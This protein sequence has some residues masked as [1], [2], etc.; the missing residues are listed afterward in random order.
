MKKRPSALAVA[1]L[2]LLAVF[3]LRLRQ[4]PA[5][6]N[7]GEP[8]LAANERQAAAGQAAVP[9]AALAQRLSPESW[10]PPAVFSR[11]GAPAPQFDFPR[12]ENFSRRYH[13]PVSRALPRGLGTR[14][15]GVLALTPE[16]GRTHLLPGEIDLHTRLARRMVFD[17]AALDA[18]LSGETVRALAPT[19]GDEVL[20]LEFHSVKTR[21]A[22]SHTLLGRVVGEEESSDALLVYH[23]GVIHGSV[24]RYSA[25]ADQH[26]EYR[27]LADGHMMVRELDPATM[28]A[29]CGNGPATEAEAL[30]DGASGEGLE[31]IPQ[32]EG[33]ISGDTAGWRTIDIVVGYD[34]GARVEDGGYTQIEARIISSVDRMSAAFANSAI[35]NT[36]LM[37]LGTVE[38]PFYVFPGSSAGNMGEELGNLNN[39]SDG[40]LDTVSG[41]ATTL[42]AD[43]VS[44]VTREADGSAGIAYRPGRS[45]ITARTYMTS[46]RITFAH[47]V[48]H[49]LG[50][51]HSWGDSS[52]SYHTHYGWRLEP[53]G[54]TR[55]RTIMAYD[56]GW[57]NGH[58]IPYFANPNVS[59]NGAATGTVNGYN[60]TGDATADQ[61]Y[62][63]GGLGYTGSDPNRSG[64]DGT[65]ANLAA[66]NANTINTG[67]GNGSYGATVASNRAVRTA[68]NVTSPL[69]GAE[70]PRVSAQTISFNGGDMDDLFSI[71]LYK[72]GS[73]VST[74]ASGLN[75]ATSRNFAWTVPTGL[76]SG[77]DYMIRVTLTAPGGGNIRTADSQQ[78][79]IT[80]NLPRIVSHTPAASPSAPAPV[81]QLILSF[82]APMNPATFS[83]AQD[84]VS[85]T[86]PTGASLLPAITGAAW[87]NSDTTLTVSFSAQST[88]GLHRMILG[89][90]ISDMQGNPMDQ[91]GDE[92]P[93]ESPD[94]RY[95]ADFSITPPPIYLASMAADP[96]WSLDAGWAFGQPTGQGQD[97]YGNPDPTAGFNGPNVI[98]YRLDGDYEASLPTT[99]WATTPAI[100][101]SGRENT[102]L[103]YR[104][105]LGVESSQYDR[106]F[107]QVSNNGSTWTT[108]WE[109]PA[110]TVDDGA[111]VSI[112]HDISA[113][114]DG[115]PTVFIRWGIGP[116]DSSWQWCGWNLDEVAVG[117]D[118]SP[119]QGVL[120]V[121]PAGG[122]SPTGL[123]GGPFL[124]SSQQYTLEN[125]GTGSLTWTAVKTAAWL[126]LSST[127]GTLAAGASTTVTVSLNNAANSLAIGSHGDTIAFSN[128]SNGTGDTTR[129][130]NLT[131]VG[132]GTL[133]VG[134][135]DA[136]DASGNYGGPFNPA[137]REYTLGNP[138]STSIDWTASKAADWIS[139]SATGGTLAPGAETTVTVSL[140]AAADALDTGSYADSVSFTNTTNGNG[141]TTRNVSLTVD[142]IPVGVT[143]GGL[144]RSYDGS[145]KPVSVTT[146]PPGMAYSITYG[147]SANPPTD[148]GIYPVVVA[149]TE[150]NHSGGAAD[151]LLIAK[152]QQTI[153]FAELDPIG[154]D[155]PPFALTA[156]A[157][158][159]LAVSYTSSATAVATVAGNILT[160][161]GAGTT[162]ITA[163][164]AGDANHEPAP[165]VQRSL[166]VFQTDLAV[167]FIHEAFE[168]TN[169][170]LTGNTAGRGLVGTWLGSGAVAAGSLDYGNLPAGT[171][172][173]A[174]IS[175]QNGYASTG[176][177][178]AAPGLMDDGATLWF[179]V[180]VRTGSDIATN[181]DFGFAF[182]TDPIGSGNN[183]PVSND[184]TALGFTF[185][186]NQ[187]RASAWEPALTRSGNNS[188]NGAAPESTYLV[189]GKF[190]W[191]AG[192][193]TLQIYNVGT[194]LVLANPVSTWSG[195]IDQ[196]LFD[197]ISFGA[198]GANPAHGIDEI[199]FGAS[200]EAVIGLGA[201]DPY[202]AWAGGDF[203][204]TFTET[205]PAANPDGDKLTNLQ[206]FAFGTDPTLSESGPITFVPGGAIT[207]PGL[208]TLMNLA[209][210][211]QADDIRAVFARR[212]DHA[213]AGLVY[214]V[215][216]SGDMGLWTASGAE[217][218]VLTDP[219]GAGDT[220]VVSVPFPALVPPA[221]GLENIPPK[222]FRI[223]VSEE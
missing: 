99:R 64:F 29:T 148:A 97:A 20:T 163:S 173:K 23:D 134:P 35:T 76:A 5:G 79:S 180:V 94:D 36:E 160:P 120:A 190:T 141:D 175:S 90:N 212:K 51:D 44:F 114:A 165:S 121:T 158:S 140:S 12:G 84:I 14:E 223:G 214:A 74:I 28:T 87:S 53:P 207:S 17:P 30:F 197:T 125:S 31:I 65:N 56:W 115:Q 200:Y 49:N 72:G 135:A 101:C 104:R 21:S 177:T 153:T 136:L 159:G 216:F 33:E 59:Y 149:I 70:W 81:T 102:T 124:P 119:S 126:D 32:N 75:P 106:A 133:A 162:V 105:W 222:F 107:V 188:G 88:P 220:E 58:R 4:D 182:G 186:N 67:G 77:T 82:N 34:A 146:S 184:G 19:V 98:G 100:N 202:S 199:R 166:T 69:S 145:P 47:E 89:P 150:P 128:I 157:G 208:P 211:G 191:G 156:T 37:L 219:N 60:A 111:W 172:G 130:V 43:M 155:E 192:T 50:C 6:E 2:L 193:D 171:G 48:G 152:A 169:A 139:L 206:E 71:T 63:T 80:G 174:S 42:G 8:P 127:G 151:D 118:A 137:S 38:D 45:S 92:I 170:T 62:V 73:L 22:R 103:T 10:V 213:A 112:Q 143:L 68:F 66:N 113:V 204:G 13:V 217:P 27:I 25:A 7:Q 144:T 116:T 15:P 41:F 95:T 218:T 194:N 55:V 93:G 108:V 96:G 138:G 142:P 61:R 154:A 109:N 210:P 179:S 161:E 1:L 189:V 196:T 9:D 78:F 117:G 39:F 11:T 18:V 110:S 167:A 187:L 26:L 54:L 181:G 122:F 85:F 203:S 185:K 221:V 129:P 86:S 209:P 46:T 168:D 3:L 57:G 198:K 91:D 215:E 183:L 132:P 205:A 131:V 195:A 201:A 83:V 52:Q 147:G 178:L 164:Q 24:A 123:A 176:T 16:D 40:I